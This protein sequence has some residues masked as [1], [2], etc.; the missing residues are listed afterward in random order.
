MSSLHGLTLGHILGENRRNYPHKA[1]LVCRD[2]RYTYPEMD[3]RVNRLANALLADGLGRGDRILWL[4]QNCHRVLEGLLAAAKIGAVFCPVNW[5]QTA[6]ELAF[7]IDDVDARVVIWQEEEIGEAVRG[8]RERASSNGRWLRHDAVGDATYEAF[9]AQGTPTEPA[10]EIDPADPVLMLYTAAFAGRPNGA[11][12]SHTAITTQDMVMGMQQELTAEYVYLNSGPLFHIATFMTTLAT[13]HF[14]GTNVFTRRVDAEELCR[15][16]AAERC[17]G[18]FILPP[19][20]DQI[21]EVNRDGTYDLSSLR[22]FAGK[23]E[24]TEMI[25]VDTS[26]WSRHPGGYGQTEVMG[27]LTLNSWG[28]RV[29]GTHGRPSPMV[30]VRVVDPDGNEVAPGETG[31]IVARGPTVMTRYWNRDEV[32]AERQAGGWHHTNDLGRRE[33]DGSITF[34]GPKTRIVKSAA[35]NIYPAEV[36]GCLQKHPAVREA[37]IIGVPDPKWTQSVKAVVVLEEGQSATEEEIIEH[38]RAHIASYK[39]PRSVEFV[40]ALPRAGWLVDYDAL[41]ARFGGGGYPG[42][43][44]RSA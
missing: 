26:A 44:N 3:D 25:T 41:D 15:I 30:Q 27:M 34:I 31:E 38:C 11:M 12:L 14:G 19:T 1:A 42:G 29:E 6:E 7:V 18:A 37:A 23:P 5:R 4:G 24:W 28:G 10:L 22:T 21:V 35:E 32:N 16:I 39:K 8:A 33:P 36:E 43:R 20:M 17:T 13:F 2:D 9:L 40:D